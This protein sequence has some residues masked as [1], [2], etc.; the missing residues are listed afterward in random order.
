KW[1]ASATA[2][3][4]R[5]RRPSLAASS[6]GARFCICSKPRSIS[7]RSPNRRSK[8]PAGTEAITRGTTPP[9]VAA[10]SQD[11]KKIERRVESKA[12]RPAQEIEPLEETSGARLLVEILHEHLSRSGERVFPFAEFRFGNQALEKDDVPFAMLTLQLDPATG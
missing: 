12:K 8:P 2:A 9:G 5:I 1:S 10:I 3:P 7:G 11:V 6:A 4:V